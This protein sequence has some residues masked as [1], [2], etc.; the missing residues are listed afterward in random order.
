MKSVNNFLKALAVGLPFGSFAIT[1]AS[2][3]GGAWGG[4]S[5]GIERGLEMGRK[6]EEERLIQL[7]QIYLQ[8]EIDRNNQASEPTPSPTPAA[9]NS[10]VT[11]GKDNLLT[12]CELSRDA[13]SAYIS[14]VISGARMA[15]SIWDSSEDKAKSTEWTRAWICFGEGAVHDH[16]VDYVINRRRSLTAPEP[17]EISVLLALRGAFNCPG[18]VEFIAYPLE[19]GLTPN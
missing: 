17:P 15:S 18:S 13:C 1:T 10:R 8:Q 2:A 14:G 9:D 19:A 6:A 11:N 12:M 4:L 16:F 5:R 7:Q 3:E